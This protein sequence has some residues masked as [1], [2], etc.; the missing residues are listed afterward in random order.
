MPKRT[1]KNGQGSKSNQ[2]KSRMSAKKQSLESKGFFEL[3]FSNPESAGKPK[4][5]RKKQKAADDNIIKTEPVKKRTQKDNRS[6][7]KRI[8]FAVKKRIANKRKQAALTEN[9]RNS[10]K[11]NFFK[12]AKAIIVVLAARIAAL[13]KKKGAPAVNAAAKKV[14][15]RKLFAYA[16]AGTLIVAVTLVFI[17]V[18]DGRAQTSEDEIPGSLLAAAQTQQS[19]PTR[20]PIKTTLP[21]LTRPDSETYENTTQ[22]T[23]SPTKTPVPT[24]TATPKPTEKPTPKPTEKPTPKPTE[25]PTPKP[26]EKPTPTPE[27]SQDIDG[28][29]ASY[30]VESDS[31]YNK[32][33]FDTNYY[34]YTDTDLLM[35]A[36]V[37]HGESKNESLKGKIAVGNVIMNRVLTPN[38]FG[39]TIKA[40]VEAPKQFTAYNPD[41]VPSQECYDA[42]RMVLDDQNWV[43]PQNV[44]FFNPSGSAGRNTLYEKIGNHYFFSYNYSGRNNNGLVPDAL[45]KRVYEWPRYGCI[46]AARVKN[47]QAMLAAL[48]YST[49]A[50]GYFGIGTE[51]A[52][53]KFQS[54]HGLTADGV[55][56]QA[57]LKKLINTYGFDKYLDNF[58]N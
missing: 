14:K 45:F 38:Y 24:T 39:N 51:E 44:Y 33:G 6:A 27:P 26:T 31:Y 23:T 12:V 35:V 34:D 48:G 30:R 10:S 37:I 19:E 43:V 57:T 53:K 18:P 49:S 11:K 29:V 25:K 50:D 47:M 55:A 41:T 20:T 56:G 28:V 8:V 36:Q 42:A 17:L 40:V 7:V 52:L 15:R 1:D 5:Y 9:R 2:Q 58:V 54:D 3:I 32:M 4:R 46:P 13:F 16:G 22:Q 21:E